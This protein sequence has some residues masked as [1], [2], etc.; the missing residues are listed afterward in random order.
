MPGLGFSTP[1]LAI[2]AYT[3]VNADGTSGEQN[4]GVI[5]TRL[6]QGSYGVI[7][8]TTLEQDNSQ[9]FIQVQPL[10]NA[11]GGKNSVVGFAANVKLINFHSKSGNPTLGYLVDTRFNC[12][13]LRTAINPPPGSPA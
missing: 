3:Q 5:T 10:N 1:D 13:I 4:S 7:L 12:L 6:Q 2:V 9:C 11:S 8:P